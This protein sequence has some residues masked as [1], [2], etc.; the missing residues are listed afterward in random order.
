MAEI[1]AN[2]SGGTA[3]LILNLHKKWFN[4]VDSGFKKEEYRRIIDHWTKRLLDEEKKPKP[5][6]HVEFRNG[7]SKTPP[8]TKVEYLGITIKRPNPSW[9]PQNAWDKSFLTIRLGYKLTVQKMDIQELL[10]RGFE[11][12][13]HDGNGAAVRLLMPDEVHELCWYRNENYIRYQTR[14]SGTTKQLTNVKTIQ[15]LD[16]YYNQ[17][18][19][20][21]INVQK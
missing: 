12:I 4:M 6:S 10:D 8:T 21:Q 2:P 14:D 20:K 15:D 9:S 5:F 19:N 18:T 7:Y 17:I 16:A 13:S 11:D 3:P 1:I